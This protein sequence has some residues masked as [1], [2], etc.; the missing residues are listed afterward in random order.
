MEQFK[1]LVNCVKEIKFKGP[2]GA[3]RGRKGDLTNSLRIN[4][5]SI[6]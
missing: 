6:G 1:K 4:R 2:S 3:R 5:G